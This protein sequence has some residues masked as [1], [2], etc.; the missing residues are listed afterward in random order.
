MAAK[1]YEVHWY[2]RKIDSAEA[3]PQRMPIE[4]KREALAFAEG[5]RQ[6]PLN[7]DIRVLLQID[8]PQESAS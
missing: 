7:A 2:S 8:P 6:S 1:K 4:S 3:R 5:L